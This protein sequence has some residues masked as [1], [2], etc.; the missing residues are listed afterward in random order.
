MTVP[1]ARPAAAVAGVIGPLN[2]RA[3]RKPVEFDT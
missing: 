2:S 1:S 3:M